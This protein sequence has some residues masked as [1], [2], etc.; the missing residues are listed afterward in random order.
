MKKNTKLSHTPS[1]RRSALIGSPTD[2]AWHLR[3]RTDKPHIYISRMLMMGEPRY[4]LE[5][6]PGWLINHVVQD[7]LLTVN[8][9]F[10]RT[11]GEAARAWHNDSKDI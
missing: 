6:Q 5:T 9:T 1:M 11:A 4:A 2:L 7:W 10:Y 8:P 3:T